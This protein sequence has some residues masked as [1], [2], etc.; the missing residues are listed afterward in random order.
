[1]KKRCCFMLLA[2]VALVFAHPNF[3]GTN[4][5]LRSISAD[6]LSAGHFHAGFF[7]RGFYEKREAALV[8]DSTG[9]ANH[10]GGDIFFGFGYS[11]TDYLSFN[12]T[13]SYH[14][15]G[16]DYID[17]EYNRASIGFGDTKI[18]LKLGF[19]R[20]N[21]KFGLYPFISL[22]T[23]EDRG[24]TDEEMSS[25]PIFNDAYGNKGG[26]FRYFSSGATDYGAIGLFT[27]KTG[28]MT[29]DLNLGYIFRNKAGGLRSNA[30]TYNA[31]LSWDLGGVVPFIEVSEVDFNG[32]DQFFTFT[33]DSIFG[34][35]AVYLT[36][37]ISFRP[38][39]FNINLAVDIRFLEGENEQPFPTA[40]TDSF[41]IPTGWGATP[42]WAAILGFSY[43]YD[44]IPEM[45]KLG[46]IAGTIIDSKTE[47]GIP[48]NVGIYQEGTLISSKTSGVDGSFA[49]GELEPGI[50]KLDA[51]AT[52][53]EPYTVD[54]LVKAGEVTPISVALVP[55]PTE[56]ILVLNIMDIESKEPMVAQVTIG[57]MA[58]ELA[59]GKL[60]KTLRA[61]SYTIK[62]VPEAE[63]YLPYERDITIE[64]GMTLEL[65]VALVKKEFKIVLP[66]VYF[67]TAKAEIKPESYPI[68]DDAAKT[69][70]T[71]LSGNPDITIEV[72][73][74]TDS[75]GSDAYNQNLS[76][77]RADAVKDYLVI[78]HGITS[79]RLVAR[80]YG[81]SQPIAS[82]NTVQGM[83]KN[84]RVE[85]LILK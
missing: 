82:N 81:E 60:E 25:Y 83:A 46:E 21:I 66:Q 29:V 53:Y 1:M 43:C 5:L 44:F 80:G 14:G 68:L 77:E 79:A 24:P 45:P 50:Y 6:N 51:A 31:A 4:G 17:S 55:V 9:E 48:A 32:K 7:L 2:I 63:N 54:L 38:G 49:F 22:P 70:H 73:G 71:V 56:G 47:E 8:G 28:I 13:S 76:Q 72:Q 84:R 58:P 62:A 15:D 59:D 40:L 19:G 18:G 16:V 64:P 65:E 30:N 52:D 10:G 69:I 42:A 20:S 23:G 57:S 61:G 11:I 36:P 41:N 39:H 75:R 34:V 74:H 37:G 12:V 67:E 33:D 78:K 35:N 3:E 27:L 85:F 26:V